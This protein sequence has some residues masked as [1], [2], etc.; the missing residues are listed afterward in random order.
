[1]RSR[2]PNKYRE[3]GADITS[4][5]RSPR[6]RTRAHPQRDHGAAVGQYDRIRAHAGT[7]VQ[8]WDEAGYEIVISPF[9][10]SASPL[11]RCSDFMGSL[12][13]NGHVKE[14]LP[15]IL[16]RAALYDT[17]GYYDYE[18]LDTSIARTVLPEFSLMDITLQHWAIIGW[19]DVQRV[20]LP[21]G[22]AIACGRGDREG[23][24][25]PIQRVFDFLAHGYS[26]GMRANDVEGESSQD[27]EVLRAI[28]FSG[29]AA[30]LANTTSSTQCSRFSMAQ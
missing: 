8:G 2:V 6:A 21:P 23:R 3:A 15:Q 18:A 19:D 5:K 4:W 7:F 30:I 11:A 9:R 22:R 17:I 26:A 28:V 24:H 10:R 14:M 27:G 20:T 16:M 29:S 1:M 13:E 12:R 25:R